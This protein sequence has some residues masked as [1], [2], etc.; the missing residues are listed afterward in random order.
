M[1]SRRLIVPRS[2]TFRPAVRVLAH[3]G[4]LLAALA[5]PAAAQT[6]PRQVADNATAWFMYF[7]DHAI[8]GRWALHAEAQVRR[9]DGVREWQQLLLRPGLTYTLA[10]N[11]RVTAGYAFIDTWAYGAQ[12]ALARFPEHRSWQQLQVGHATGRVGW[13][14][15][16][17]LEQRWVQRPLDTA[18]TRDRAYTNRMR[19][20]ARATLPLRGR[21]LELREPYVSVYDEVMVNWG[22][23]VGRNVFDQNRAYGALG[24]R[25][26]V[27]TRV[28]A[29]YMQQLI[30]KGD[31][32]QLERNHTLQLAVFQGAALPRF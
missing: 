17:R 7:G 15:R 3:I 8:T 2:A 10:P 11:A 19:Y 23:N 1:N 20:L 24:W 28:E 21:T 29:G 22:R 16:Y 31:G 27:T 4:A 26:T 12:P 6:G 30:L 13:Q 9:A 25:A 18:G 5:R 32:V 14:H